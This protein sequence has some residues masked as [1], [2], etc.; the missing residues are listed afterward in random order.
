MLV[1]CK[2]NQ[3]LKYRI[4]KGFHI[5]AAIII[6][7]SSCN[8]GKTF[9]GAI[10]KGL[11]FD[12]MSIVIDYP[13]LSSYTLHSSYVK[14]DTLFWSGYNH[15]THCIDIFDLTNK[16]A[17]KTIQL[18]KEGPN[19]IINF[20]NYILADSFL[21]FADYQNE[22]SLFSI[23]NKIVYKRLTPVPNSMYRLCYNGL[24]SGTYNSSVSMRLHNNSLIF[25]IYPIKGQNTDDILAV[26]LELSTYQYSNLPF[27]YPDGMIEDF[28]Q[29][30]S[31]TYIS[32]MNYKDRIVFNFPYSS[33]IY[34][35]DKSSSQI[36][37]IPLD[38]KSTKNKSKK[39]TALKR[40][41]SEVFK[42]EDETLRFRETY[43]FDKSNKYVRIH[44]NDINN[45]TNI[46]DTYLITYN[47]ATQNVEEYKIPPFFSHIYFA[48]NEN[49]VF[50]LNSSND[51][52][53]KFAIVDIN[54]I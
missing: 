29:Y 13:Y 7:L 38:S 47:N 30:G 39:M 22:I 14:L 28:S 3:L 34:I 17:H 10:D 43:Y 20:S 19:G 33:N 15:M 35:Y 51:N 41:Y 6:L 52:E 5:L 26:N 42:Y 54:S 46:R 11:R 8:N 24:L 25:P 4:M 36:K 32:L 49:L 27:T 31:L 23:P 16:K 45:E 40:D 48:A 21:V 1:D 18:E 44:H 50:L 12:T 53:L 37:S 9:N 2:I